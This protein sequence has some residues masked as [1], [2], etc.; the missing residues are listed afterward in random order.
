[1]PFAGPFRYGDPYADIGEFAYDAP[2][3]HVV[4]KAVRFVWRLISVDPPEATSRKRTIPLP[5]GLSMAIQYLVPAVRLTPGIA[6]EFQVP[7]AGEVIVPDATNVPGSLPLVFVYTPTAADV[8]ALV[9]S[10]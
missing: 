6:T 2:G 10:T 1:M 5:L 8:A 4:G 7:F 9:L 3:D